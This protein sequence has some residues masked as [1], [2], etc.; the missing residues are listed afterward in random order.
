M[1]VINQGLA[2]Q[3]LGHQKAPARRA[4]MSRA[5]TLLYI[6]PLQDT[7]QL[8][9]ALTHH[10]AHSHPPSGR[11]HRTLRLSQTPASHGRLR[12][13]RRSR[14]QFRPRASRH[15]QTRTRNPRRNAPGRRR[16]K[17]PPPHPPH[18]ARPGNHA[19]RPRRRSRSHRRS[20]CRRRR[21]S[22]QAFQR[23]RASS[24]HPRGTPPQRHF[25][26]ARNIHHR[27]S[28]NRQRRAPHRAIRRRHRADRRRIRYSGLASPRSRKSAHPRR[29][30]R[31]SPG[32]PR[33]PA[34]SQHRQSHQQSPQK[35][36]PARQ[37]RRKNSQRPR[38]RLHLHR[39]IQRGPR[40][41]RGIFAKI[42]LW[43]WFAMA[44]LGVAMVSFTLLSG[45]QPIGQRW[46]S[47]AIDLYVRSAV[48]FYHQGGAPLL[49]KYLDDIAKSNGIRAALLDPQG[50]DLAAQGL[51]PG[52]ETVIRRAISTGRTQIQTTL[53]WSGAS[54]VA[55]PEGT[56]IFVAQV[57]AFRG[58][59]RAPDLGMALLRLAIS[60]LAAGLLCALLARHIAKPIRALQSAASRIAEGDLSVRA[61]PA[62]APRND[63]LADLAS[64]FD[65]MAD[66]IQSLLQKQQEL[67]GDISHELRSPLA[68]LSISL[69]LARR[70]DQDALEHMQSDLTRLDELIGEILTLTRLQSHDTQRTA[71]PVNLRTILEGVAADARREGSAESKSINFSQAEDCWLAGDPNLL[72]SCF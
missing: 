20:G 28:R 53:T 61:T 4:T 19:N 72:R 60:L 13:H 18:L 69:E 51:P 49:N 8:N 21:L 54:P 16:P 2:I 46:I 27:R 33:R 70:G 67:L 7:I 14:S 5:T 71:T 55:T 50:R 15:Q 66:R 68:R 63:E 36:G 6:V 47:R 43:F 37:R 59:L 12:S 44:A 62:I 48:D 38:I 1:L 42:F 45:S 26:A 24:A 56:Y 32:P 52:T 58:L 57:H 39:R 40:I 30:R 3:F 41:M 10:E 29:N 31:T 64:D 22:S 9:E 23:P 17:S 11:R 35:I 65:R 34:R 25:R